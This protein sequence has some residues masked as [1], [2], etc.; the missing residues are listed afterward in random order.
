M[1]IFFCISFFFISFETYALS[2]KC[3]FEEVYKNGD[4]QQGFFLLKDKDL[5]YEYFNKS[6]YTVLYLNNRLFISEN[7]D[8]TKTQIIENRNTVL[9]NLMKIYD[10]YPD[11]KDNYFANGYEIKV[12]LNNN[13]FIKRISINSIDLSLSIYFLNCQKKDLQDEY[14]DFNPVIDYVYSSK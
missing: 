7:M 11:I 4:T 13:K 12:D 14:F 2:I 8:R 9:P 1:K 5:R 6:L 3:D 10:E